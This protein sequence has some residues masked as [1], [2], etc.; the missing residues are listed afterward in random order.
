M[1]I[2]EKPPELSAALGERWQLRSLGASSFCDTWQATRGE[3]KLFVKSTGRGGA[4]MLRAEADGLR[5]LAATRTIRVPQV[6]S[7]TELPGGGMVLALE[8]LHFGRPDAGFGQ[9][10]GRDLAALHAHPCPLEPASFGWRGDNFIGATPQRNTPLQPPTHAGWLA[11]F[12]K[13]RLC[14][15]KDKL[16]PSATELRS[17]VEAV[18]EKLPDLFADGHMPRP[19]LIHGD[20]WQGNWDMLQDGTPVIFDPAVSCSDPQADVAMMELFGSPPAGFRAGYEA[21]GGSWPAPQRQQL[22]Q[23]YH[24]LNHA[25]L[26]DGGYA[27][28]ALR[29][30]R[31]LL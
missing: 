1:E 11:F 30:A 22:Y 24:L 5:A 31:S 2:I 17:A 8:W 9:R 13:S 18:I 21:A 23:L 10:F 12:A 16:A 14:C 7:L 20:L 27:Q 28:Q 26:F 19:A 29:C 3:Q 15:M 6:D 25:I 4:A